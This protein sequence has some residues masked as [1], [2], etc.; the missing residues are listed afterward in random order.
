[1]GTCAN[2]RTE[3]LHVGQLRR[4]ALVAGDFFTGAYWNNVCQAW[5]LV[6]GPSQVTIWIMNNQ[7]GK[8]FQGRANILRRVV[9]SVTLITESVRSTREGYVLTRFCLSVHTWGG[10]LHRP[11]PASGVPKPGPGRRGTPA[12]SR[13]GGGYPSQVQAG[14]TT[15]RSRWRVPDHLGYPLSHLAKGYPTSGIPPARQTWPGGY[16]DGGV[17]LDMPWSVCLLRSHRR[18]FLCESYFKEGANIVWGLVSSV[19]QMWILFQGRANILWGLVSSV[20]QMWILFQGRGQY[21]MGNNLFCYI[22]VDLISREVPILY[23]E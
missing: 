10:G 2:P 22:N 3:A 1:M 19:T 14:D 11:G 21:C 15:A 20:T 23:G 7:S 8:L 16:P 12:G 18:T 17:V 9:S 6:T 5:T 4:H 13:R